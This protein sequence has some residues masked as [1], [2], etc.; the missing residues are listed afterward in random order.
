[1]ADIG[2]VVLH[3]LLNE[4]SLGAWTRLKLAFFSSSHASIYS[5]INKYYIKH[6]AIPNFEDLLLITR[7]GPLKRALKALESL[8]TPDVDIDLAMEALINEFTQNEALLQIDKFVDR[9]TMMDVQEVKD[10]I[11]HILLH[12]DEKTHTS[13][14]IATMSDVQLFDIDESET[15]FPMGLNN[16]YDATLGGTA[17]QELVLFGGYRGSGKSVISTNLMV[18]QYLM[19]NSSIYFSIE[20]RAQEVFTRTMSI[21]A[22]VNNTNLTR[23]LSSDN[24]V[25]VLAQKRADMFVDGQDLLEEYLVHKDYTKFE[26]ELNRTKILKPDNQMVIIDDQGLTIP[27][28]DLHLQNFKAQFGDKLKLVVVD[29][30]NQIVAEDMYNWQTQLTLS[31]ELKNLARKHNVCVVAPYQIDATGEARYS[32]GILDAADRAFILKPQDHDTGVFSF[33]TTKMRNGTPMN[34]SSTINWNSLKIS[35]VDVPYEDKDPKA[36]K[37][38]TKKEP[39]V[40]ELKKMSDDL[41]F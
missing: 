9:I 26:K 10:E 31:K 19:G 16:K 13:E 15:L 32:K 18:N 23:G 30:V 24:E 12:L 40:K 17:S 4:R 5:A 2:S 39:K 6:Q 21:L 36:K 33:E 41:E 22:D 8:E 27:S 28:I 1:M 34:F 20:M 29:Y 14:K 25:M 35:P 3:K 7:D 38:V 37:K 11:A